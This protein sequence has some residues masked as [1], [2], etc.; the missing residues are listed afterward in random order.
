MYAKLLLDNWGISLTLEQERRLWQS[1]NNSI[2]FFQ[3]FKR[4][5]ISHSHI[6]KSAEFLG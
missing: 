6:Q 2:S 4:S 3:L 5:Q 1:K